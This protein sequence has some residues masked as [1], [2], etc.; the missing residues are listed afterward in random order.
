VLCSRKITIVNRN[1]FA[2]RK[3]RGLHEISMINLIL[4]IILDFP[5]LTSLVLWADNI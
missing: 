3:E 2:M 5:L 4:E 1:K